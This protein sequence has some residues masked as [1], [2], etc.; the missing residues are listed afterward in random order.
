M[1]YRIHMENKNKFN[2]KGSIVGGIVLFGIFTLIGLYTLFYLLLLN[3]IEFKEV[4]ENYA[5]SGRGATIKTT[6]IVNF[7]YTFLGKIGCIM[8]LSL[9]TLLLMLSTAKEIK[10]LRRYLHKEKLFK[11]GL[12]SDMDDDCK[13][14][15][16]F[17]FIKSLFRKN[18]NN[19]RKVKI[20]SRRELKE[21]KRELLER[22]STSRK[23]K[24][25]VSNRDCSERK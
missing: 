4:I 10:T 7:I 22:E 8:F 2:S 24:G 11:M 23:T 20:Y 12:V 25:N 18:K 15:S 3:D 13:P 6:A 9:G 17:K 1:E 16:L 5:N 19:Q 21:M 14:L